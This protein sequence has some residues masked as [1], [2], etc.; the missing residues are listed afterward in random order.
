MLSPSQVSSLEIPY[1]F[2]SS[3]AS[4]RVPPP[5]P[6]PPLLPSSPDILLHRG[7]E[8]LQAQGFA[9]PTDVQQGHSLPHKWLELLVPPCVFF[10]WWSSLQ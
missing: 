7:I 3:T 9:L 6:P 2:P 4:M 1:P 10:G 8:P 5:P